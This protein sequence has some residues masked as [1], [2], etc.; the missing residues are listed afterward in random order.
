MFSWAI[1]SQFQTMTDPRKL[2]E[3]GKSAVNRKLLAIT[4]LIRKAVNFVEIWTQKNYFN[5]LHRLFSGKVLRSQT[6]AKCINEGTVISDALGERRGN[7]KVQKGIC[8]TR[9][10]FLFTG[11][12]GF[13]WNVSNFVII[14]LFSL[15]ADNL[16]T[17]KKTF[18]DL[19]PSVLCASHRPGVPGLASGAQTPTMMWSLVSDASAV[20]WWDVVSQPVS[21]HS[22]IWRNREMWKKSCGRE[23][24]NRMLDQ[25]GTIPALCQ[26]EI[27]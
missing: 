21:Q 2:S 4:F 9:Y 18:S 14:R 27:D 13:R 19:R 6:L 8:A 24:Y 16:E 26:R 5:C 22:S 7:S 12:D 15:K 10:S 25:V 17:F 20:L 11:D 23:S 1:S 3:F